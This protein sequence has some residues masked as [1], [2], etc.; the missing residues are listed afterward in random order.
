MAYKKAVAGED[1]GVFE[2]GR[3]VNAKKDT[4][5]PMQDM[6]IYDRMRNPLQLGGFA[7]RMAPNVIAKEQEEYANARGRVS[8]RQYERDL[9]AQLRDPESKLYQLFYG[10]RAQTNPTGPIGPSSDEL[11]YDLNDNGQNEDDDFRAQYGMSREEFDATL[12]RAG[13]S[14]QPSRAALLKGPM[15]PAME[16]GVTMEE[17]PLRQSFWEYGPNARGAHFG[18][19][20]GA[21]SVFNEV[22]PDGSVIARFNKFGYPIP[23]ETS[24]DFKGTDSL[25]EGGVALASGYDI[26][27]KMAAE[28][29]ARSAAQTAA[30]RAFSSGAAKP[31]VDAVNKAITAQNAARGATAASTRLGL[32]GLAT[33]GAMRTDTSSIGENLGELFMGDTGKSGMEKDANSMFGMRPRYGKRYFPDLYSYGFETDDHGLFSPQSAYNALIGNTNWRPKVVDGRGMTLKQ[34]SFLERAGAGMSNLGAD[35]IEQILRFN[36]GAANAP[37]FGGVDATLGAIMGGDKA[38]RLGIDPDPYGV[39]PLVEKAMLIRDSRQGTRTPYEKLE[40]MRARPSMFGG[41]TA[42]R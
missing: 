35:V 37:T 25:V 15:Q 30:S 6:S 13:D 14:I 5:V 32:L 40:P 8:A 19:P 11:D 9:D 4:Y 20:E 22:G 10:K 24:P 16:D 21:P 34:G 1:Y 7:P 18:S 26:A 29:A 33:S 12:P 28:G 2:G 17:E 36:I 27:R 23:E 38:R 39:S 3:Y 31:A 41:F 42:T